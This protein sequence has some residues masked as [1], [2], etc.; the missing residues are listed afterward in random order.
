[1][2][3]RGRPIE[4]AQATSRTQSL[5]PSSFWS[6]THCP[7]SSLLGRE[8]PYNVPPTFLLLCWVEISYSVPFTFLLLSWVERYHTVYC[9]LSRFSV[10]KRDIIQCT[11]TFL[12]LCWVERYHTV[13]HHFPASLL[14][15]EISYSVPLL[16][17]FSVG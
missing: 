1:M 14:G 15:R 9:P 4:G 13:Y 8:R 7:S 12:L 11:T 10:G 17:C 16:S 3:L 6:S 2:T 5:C